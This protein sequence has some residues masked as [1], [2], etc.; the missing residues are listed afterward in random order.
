[1]GYATIP[2]VILALANAL[3]SGNPDLDS[4]A[5]PITEIGKKISAT[6]TDDEIAQYVRWADE[7]INGAISSI[8]RIPLKRVNKGT[9]RLKAD[10]VAG[11]TDIMVEDA[12]D[13]TEG[14]VIVLNQ[15]PLCD[16]NLV[17]LQSTCVPATSPPPPPNFAEP[18]HPRRVCLWLPLPRS[19]DMNLARVCKVGFPDPVPKISA[20]MAA[21]YL[22]DRRFAAQQEGNKSDFGKVLRGQAY[23]T[24]NMILSGATKLLIADANQLVGRRYYNPALDDVMDTRAEPNK[25]FLSE[26]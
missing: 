24:L 4:G 20:K 26:T 16:Q 11:D 21:S 9:F 23:Q 22:Y 10:A 5:V 1:M 3:T 7:N 17:I 25:Q 19:F 6:V 15:G 12:N 8:H 13:F 14:D 2:E 18:P